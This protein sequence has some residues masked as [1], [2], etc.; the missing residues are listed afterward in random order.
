VYIATIES[1]LEIVSVIDDA[2]EKKTW[3]KKRIESLDSVASLQNDYD[4]IIISDIGRSQQLAQ[5]L[6]SLLI[7]LNRIKVC[8]GQ[9]IRPVTAVQLVD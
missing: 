2:C 5:K 8:T 1:G 3:L 6:Y 4:C 7:P 9:K